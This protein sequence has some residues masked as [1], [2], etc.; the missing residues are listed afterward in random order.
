MRKTVTI[1]IYK[2]GAH[3][4]TVVKEPGRDVVLD[5]AFE[6]EIDETRLTKRH[7]VVVHES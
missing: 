6:I 3:Q 2:D 7:T 5:I 1:D 4:Q